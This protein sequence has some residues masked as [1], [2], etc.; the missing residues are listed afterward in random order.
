M[1]WSSTKSVKEI[2][3]EV[4]LLGSNTEIENTEREIL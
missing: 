3:G 4:V 1:H 2:V